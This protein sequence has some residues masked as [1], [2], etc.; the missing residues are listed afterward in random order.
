MILKALALHWPCT[1]L[2]RFI[3]VKL[4]DSEK[5]KTW[6]DSMGSFLM[7]NLMKFSYN[8]SPLELLRSHQCQWLIKRNGL[9]TLVP[10][11]QSL[12]N[13]MAGNLCIHH[14]LNYY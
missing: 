12:R 10:K 11:T 4:L 14:W 8:F 6:K 5:E 3:S 13:M 9:S 7:Q 2:M 1:M